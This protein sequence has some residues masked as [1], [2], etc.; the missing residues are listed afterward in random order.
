VTI[1]HFFLTV[2]CVVAPF[3]IDTSIRWSGAHGEAYN[4]ALQRQAMNMGW[5]NFLSD[6]GLL[7]QPLVWLASKIYSPKTFS[8]VIM[9]LLAIP[10]WSICFGWLF[11]KLDNWLN[12]FP[13]LGKKVF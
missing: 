9:F 13:V 10:F 6:V 1:A 11:V 5:M 2:C 4:R 3:F 8:G 7:L 12:H